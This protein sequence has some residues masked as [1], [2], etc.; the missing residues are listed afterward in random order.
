MHCHYKEEEN[1]TPTSLNFVV[2]AI[3]NKNC[4]LSSFLYD[5]FLFFLNM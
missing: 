2:K 1:K 5:C 3:P 4:P